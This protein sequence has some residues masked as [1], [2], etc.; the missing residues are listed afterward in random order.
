MVICSH[1]RNHAA[2]ESE[3]IMS[4][5]TPAP[6]VIK[7]LLT[8]EQAAQ[9]LG[10]NKRSLERYRVVGTGPAFVKLGRLCLYR[11]GDLDAWVHGRTFTSSKQAKAA[12]NAAKAATVQS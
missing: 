2:F 12:I 1:R 5:E 11:E 6:S 10:L 4:K 8:G 3:R 9:Y 7:D